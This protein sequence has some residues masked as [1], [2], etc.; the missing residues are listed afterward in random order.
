LSGAC[1]EV[2]SIRAER[3]VDASRRQSSLQRKIGAGL[4][5]A[6]FNRKVAEG[7]IKHVGLPESVGLIALAMVEGWRD[8]GENNSYSC[9]ERGEQ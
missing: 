8:T 4:M 7:V 3:I 2:T 5:P 1:Q 9:R 6:E